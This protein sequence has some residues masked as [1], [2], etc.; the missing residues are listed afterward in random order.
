M[1]LITNESSFMKY[2]LIIY[3]LLV[4]VS[5]TSVDISFVFFVSCEPYKIMIK[6]LIMLALIYTIAK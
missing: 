2:I 5:V 3:S 1:S 6:H 4:D